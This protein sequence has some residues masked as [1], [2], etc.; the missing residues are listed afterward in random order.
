MIICS[1]DEEKVKTAFGIGITPQKILNY[2]CQNFHGCVLKRK[3]KEI[4]KSEKEE[5]VFGQVK[6]RGKNKNYH[7]QKL[8]PE[9]IVEIMYLW[10]EEH[11]LKSKTAN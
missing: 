9:N 10:F 2:F 6:K 4:L 1:I 11:K 5:E 3:Q 7:L 8:L